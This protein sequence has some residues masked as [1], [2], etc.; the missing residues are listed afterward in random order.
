M[1][2]Y[3]YVGR[4]INTF[5]IK[6]EI[7]VKSD[8][9]YIDRVLMKDFPIYIGIAKN[10][11]T[12]LSY[13]I[14]KNNYLISLNGY[15]NINDILKY[16]GNSIYV[17]RNDLNLNS[18]EYLLKDLIDFSVYDEDILLGKVIDYEKNSQY[19]LLKIKGDKTFYI[20]NIDKYIKNI[21]LINKRIITNKGSE[22][23]L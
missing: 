21:D 10:K 13:R 11:E 2:N 17:L 20:P 5:G 6:G 4:I 19:V 8:F 3:I 23:V 12:I 16:K 14:H 15:I 1:N 22:L 18:N 7:K 9:E